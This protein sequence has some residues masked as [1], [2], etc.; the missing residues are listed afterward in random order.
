[1]IARRYGRSRYD[2]DTDFPVRKQTAAHS[3][4]TSTIVLEFELDEDEIEEFKAEIRSNLNGTL[5]L[6]ISFG[7]RGVDVTVRKPGRGGPS[8]TKKSN[9]IANF[10]SERIRFEYIPPIRTA[11][12]A[13]EVIADLVEQELYKLE[14]ND[15]YSSALAK[16]AELQK[17]VFDA[18]AETIKDTVSGF[19]PSV[20]SV[21]LMSHQRE[22]SRALRRNIEIEVDDGELTK[23]ERKG[24][25][26]QSL[27][28][29]ALMR[30]ASQQTASG[31]SSVIAIE[32]PESHLHPRAIHELREVIETLSEHNQ[33]VLSSHSPLFVK[34]E[35]LN[36]TVIV[37]GSK[38]A[39]A[40]HVSAIRE[41]LGVRFSDNLQN[42]RLVLLVE[43]MDDEKALSSIISSR[44]E[45]LKKAFKDGIVTFDNLGGASSLRQKASF[46]MSGTCMVQCFIDNDMEGVTA[47]KR[48]KEDKILKV[49]DVNLCS[50]P[51]LSESELEDLYDKN[52][53]QS[54]FK[55]MFGV[56][57]KKKPMGKV[58]RKWSC[59]M[60]SLFRESG[61]PWDNN[62]KFG[63]KRWMAEYAAANP[64]QILKDPLIGPLVSFV[65]TAEDKISGN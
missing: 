46:Y 24:D 5:P 15:E 65:Q 14:D 29:L 56:D 50:V 26:V 45:K 30:H 57:P 6:A 34:P 49:R 43:G 28:T 35:N 8:L 61:K 11:E 25:G 13:S 41:A 22:R 19:L 12:S 58:K 54:D 2:W 59:V 21:N 4:S 52:V 3:E 9:R 38:A 33:V 51:G 48:A 31:L 37:K 27:V 10:V 23:L 40:L 16:I 55:K 7:K 53:Y 36:N 1:M 42:A 32:E 39:C 63:V 20:K 60:E 17:P 44:S 18:L 47:V 64:G 62:I